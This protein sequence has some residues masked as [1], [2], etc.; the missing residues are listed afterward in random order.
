[1]NGVPTLLNCRRTHGNG[2]VKR[3]T[4]YENRVN[5]VGLRVDCVGEGRVFRSVM[6]LCRARLSAMKLHILKELYEKTPGVRLFIP[7]HFVRRTQAGLR[8]NF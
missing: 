7:A 8:L 2:A 4:F 3:R 6:P 5:T 1:M